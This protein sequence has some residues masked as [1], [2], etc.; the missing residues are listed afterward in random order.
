MSQNGL[1]FLFS[2][3]PIILILIMCVCVCVYTQQLVFYVILCI[4]LNASKNILLR[5]SR[6]SL[7]C[8]GAHGPQTVEDPCPKA[9]WEVVLCLAPGLGWH[10]AEAARIACYWPALY[11]GLACSL[12][13]PPNH[14][15]GEIHF[16][17]TETEGLRQQLTYS[18][19]H[20]W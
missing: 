12:C 20:S 6:A 14:P 9:S 13:N 2:I 8:R 17:D 1:P 3:S 4:F 15:V 7:D 18:R 11:Q 10:I 16:T 19:A 5:S